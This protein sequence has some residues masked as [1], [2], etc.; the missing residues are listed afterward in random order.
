M[1]EAQDGMSHGKES[2]GQMG[3]NT[4][5]LYEGVLQQGALLRP[6]AGMQMVSQRQTQGPSQHHE[7]VSPGFGG[8][9]QKHWVGERKYTGPH[10]NC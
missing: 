2:R 7:G 3:A 10:T 9:L 5:H 6:L 1:G 8:M 4:E